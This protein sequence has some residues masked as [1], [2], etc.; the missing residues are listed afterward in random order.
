G[1][2]ESLRQSG[3]SLFT[4]GFATIDKSNQTIIDF[5]AAATGPI[6]VAL[7]IG[8]LPSIYSAYL[9]REVTLT[10]LTALGGEPAWGP[11]V[12]ARA[13]L[14]GRIDELP[15]MY[16]EWTLW[17][18]HT[19]TTHI[20]YQILVWVRSARLTRHYL[21]AILAVLDAAALQAA[22][23]SKVNRREIYDLLLQGS[24]LMPVLFAYQRQ[25]RNFSVTLPHS[26]ARRNRV[27]PADL[28]N[29]PGWSQ[30][31]EATEIA[32]Y[33]DVAAALPPAALAVLKAGFEQPLQL[34]RADFDHAVAMLKRAN[35]PIDKDLDVAWLEF[36]QTRRRY[37]F[38]ALELTYLVDA[39][40]APWSGPRR[41]PTPTVWPM[42][43]SDVN[44]AREDVDG[45]A[46]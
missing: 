39:T 4:L 24:Q 37:E 43:A 32:A 27:K 46:S 23:C 44:V 16:R 19:R 22:L 30:G 29:A 17:S 8:F 21:V 18:A 31:A 41:V 40:P 28:A 7:M 6:I 20:T 34:T 13:Q 38:P 9:D 33:H 3:S 14:S 2:G 35:F 11:E 42:L 25:G 26:A 10:M 15:D 5:A 45:E 12:L 36:Q 1:L